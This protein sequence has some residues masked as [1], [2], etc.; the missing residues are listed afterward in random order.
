M[1][2][3]VVALD[4]SIR[5]EQGTVADEVVSVMDRSGLQCGSHR[6]GFEHRTGFIA[7]R[8]AEVLPLRIQLINICLLIHR[9]DLRTGETFGSQIGR[10]VEIIFTVCSHPE[11]LTGIGIHDD[12]ADILRAFAVMRF[13]PV[14]LVKRFDLLL[15]DLLDIHI[16][17]QAE[18]LAMLRR[19]GR[20]FKLRI[21]IEIAEGSSVRSVQD[22]V[23]IILHAGGSDID[24]VGE[25]DDL[26]CQGLVGIGSQIALFKPHTLHICPLPHQLVIG[27]PSQGVPVKIR[28]A[29]KV[30][31]LTLQIR[32]DILLDYLI[33][34]IPGRLRG[35]HITDRCRLHPEDIRDCLNRRFDK[36]TVF[37]DCIAVQYD[38]V[39]TVTLCQNDSVLI[40]DLSSSG[41]YGARVK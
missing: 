39:K 41:W 17:G 16:Q 31:K 36:I 24:S 10:I 26:A 29:L 3:D 33:A 22:T 2:I 28:A 11:D 13:I 5:D 40:L 34:G 20:T 30:L 7:F 23:V 1:T 27:L 6:D 25:A 19:D 14:G 15:Q 18:R 21:L 4:G 38:V 35:D 37:I 12:H 9:L 8:Y 32:R